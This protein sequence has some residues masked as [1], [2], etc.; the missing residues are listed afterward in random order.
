[1]KE[2]YQCPHCQAGLNAKRNIIIAAVKSNNP[3]NKGLV[4][5]HEDLG[6]YTVAMS[7]SLSIETGDVVDFFCPVCHVSLQAIK[8]G[9]LAE[10]IRID[11]LGNQ[12]TI[13]ISRTYGER[14]TFQLDEKKKLKTFGEQVKKYQDPDWFL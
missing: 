2:I 4:L 1:M 14:C 6:N 8:A 12:H 3:K 5:L 7:S 10:F 13:F 9:D 11:E